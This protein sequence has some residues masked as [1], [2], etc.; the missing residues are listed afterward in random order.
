MSICDLNRKHLLI[1]SSFHILCNHSCGVSRF[2]NQLDYMG[3]LVL[4][5]GAGIPSIY[6]GFI[7]HPHLQSLYWTL[8]GTSFFYLH[9]AL[10]DTGPRQSSSAAVF[11]ARFIL[12]SFFP[13]PHFRK[14]RVVFYAA[15]GL[16]CAV[17]VM[18]G[19]VIYGWELQVLHMSLVSVMY[20]AT[21]NIIGAAIYAFRVNSLR[22]NIILP[23]AHNN[24][25]R[26]P[27]DGVHAST[28][29]WGQVTKS[30]MLRL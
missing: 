22:V 23:V 10:I 2:C 1:L 16:S 6:Y 14:W 9:L 30:S 8:V 29:F 26:F 24:F 4:M 27:K 20:M 7:C 18:H 19:L 28:T 25:S 3:I 21:V 12:S 11:C 13:L 15:F 17:F 5:W